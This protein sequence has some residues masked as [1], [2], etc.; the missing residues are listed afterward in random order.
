MTDA[1][2]PH[3]QQALISSEVTIELRDDCTISRLMRDNVS[4]TA[5]DKVILEDM[6]TDKVV[7][8]G[9]FHDQVRRLAAGLQHRAGLRTD[10]VVSV[11]GPSCVDYALIAHAVWLAGG[12]LSLI[13]N[14]SSTSELVHAFNLV[15]PSMLVVGHQDVA[16][17]AAALRQTDLRTADDRIPRIWTF[18]SRVPGFQ[19]IPDDLEVSVTD[20][21]RN[22][23]VEDESFAGLE[24]DPRKHCALIVLSS[25]TSGLP[26][27]VMLSHYNLVS[28]SL[29]LRAHRPENWNGSMREVFF[30]PLSH[31][32]G[33]YVVLTMCPW[34]GSYVAIMPRFDLKQYLTLVQDRKA[35]LARLV[36]S[37]ARTLVDSPLVK[38]LSFPDLRY[39]SCSAA[40]LTVSNIFIPKRLGDMS[41]GSSYGCT[42]LTGPISQSS[43]RDTNHPLTGVGSLIANVT[44]RLVD[45]SGRT[46]DR[47]SRGE[48][49]VTSPAVMM[50]YKDNAEA[51]A[52]SFSADGWFRTG[53]VGIVDAEGCLSIVDRTKDLI[54]Y[55]GFQISP[56]ELENIILQYPDVA[57]VCVVRRWIDK[58]TEVPCAFVVVQT[59]VI[60]SPT[61]G[62]KISAFLA[63]QT[64]SYKRLRGGVTFVP[65][66]PRNSNGKIVRNQIQQMVKSLE[67]PSGKAHI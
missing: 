61:I 13:N 11:V 5:P 25:G 37:I 51:T 66:L 15:K 23:K 36:P 33:V 58:D 26:K 18:V 19:L 30:P 44:V 62:E 29:Q 46:V 10:D 55:N 39:F 63:T 41:L 35:T 9:G 24:L 64:A 56:T 4:H 65:S 6:L 59:G 53:D 60:P 8:Y 42:E 32:Y 43:V 57:E 50:G 27:A 67:N 34:I 40:P 54:K 31:V 28:S 49:W 7:T 21:V 12:T 14:S 20:E 38:E 16:K 17:V 1:Q 47:G 22:R 3:P 45:E 52:Q 48:I 2:G